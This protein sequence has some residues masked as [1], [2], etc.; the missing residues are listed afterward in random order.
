MFQPVFVV[1]NILQGNGL[2]ADVPAAERIVFVTADVQTL[3]APG[4]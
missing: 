2:R 3:V 1:V 4:Q